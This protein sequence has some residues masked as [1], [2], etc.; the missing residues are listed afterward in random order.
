MKKDYIE[1]ILK[2]LIIL[3]VILIVYWF[4]QLVFGGSPTLSQ[5]NSGFIFVIVGLVV[6]LYYKFGMFNQFTEGTFPRFE[7]NWH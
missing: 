6:H 3:G 4:L 5:F 2:S 7:I 1:I